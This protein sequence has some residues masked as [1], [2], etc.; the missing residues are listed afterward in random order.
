MWFTPEMNR[1]SAACFTCESVALKCS[2]IQVNDSDDASGRPVR[3]AAD[4][5]IFIIGIWFSL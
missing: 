5:A 4:G 3:C 1:K 2:V